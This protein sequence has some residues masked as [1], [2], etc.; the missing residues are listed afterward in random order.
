MLKIERYYSGIVE[1]RR[2]N[3]PSFAEA[4]KDMERANSRII[5]A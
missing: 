1:A 5:I 2:I 3:A 4:A